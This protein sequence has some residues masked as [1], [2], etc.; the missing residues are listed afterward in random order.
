ML[1]FNI[2]TS[3]GET[4]ESIKRKR[5]IARA[6]LGAGGA[7]R[8]VGEGLNALGDGIVAAV[9]NS[10][11]DSAEKAGMEGAA[12]DWGPIATMFGGG[13][14]AGSTATGGGDPAGDSTS[15]RGA[16]AGIESGGKYD[17]IGPQTKTGDRAYGKYQVMGAN[18]P[19]WTEQALGKRMSV[20]DFLAS[21]EAQD[22]TFDHIFGGYVQ[23]YGPEGAA[24]AWFG[25]PG[26][27][28]KVDRKDILGT[29][30]GSYGKKFMAA[31]GK[32]GA[33]DTMPYNPNGPQRTVEP[34]PN[35]TPLPPGVDPKSLAQPVRTAS[36]DPAA[37]VAKATNPYADTGLSD[38]AYRR[39]LTGETALPV[40]MPGE[41]QQVAGI[42]IG[43]QEPEPGT[44]V[45]PVQ[46]ETVQPI[47]PSNLPDQ[48]AAIPAPDRGL[49][50]DSP[51]VRALMGQSGTDPTNPNG[52]FPAPPPLRVADAAGAVP[53]QAGAPQGSSGTIQALL[54][55]AQNP[56]LSD[57]QR[58]IVKAL[59]G[60]E[61][62]KRDPA[63]QMEQEKARL[64]LDQLRNPKMTPYQEAQ[65]AE[66][67]RDDERQATAAE[68]AAAAQEA[69][70]ANTNLDNVSSLRKEVQN[71]PS[72]KNVAQAAP[73][74]KSM[75][76]TAA[77]DTKASDLNLVYGLAKIM[78]PTSVVREGEV[79]MANDTQGMADY[80]NGIIKGIQG[81]GR[82]TPEGRQA[83]MTEAYSRMKSYQDMY[84]SDIG[85][86]RGIVDRNK[87]NPADVIQ[88]FGTF[89]PWAAPPAVET[90]SAPGAG[91]EVWE[92]GPDGKIRRRP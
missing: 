69:T 51:I 9:L 82:L 89:E 35:A 52:Q 30:V 8:N 19:A 40:P 7:P 70:Q 57:G 36:L 62:K 15:Y 73:I 4:P 2:D 50:P 3:K 53:A 18:I 28:G 48:V 23:K 83:L 16:I 26:S 10:R 75:I 65:I 67:K 33:L 29:D 76:D 84:N 86:Y 45:P 63:Y 80:L 71:L 22:A 42:R 1:S 72:Y 47:D 41:G 64:E 34:I 20:K 46:P 25:G 38:E 81:E 6:L 74:Y 54:T 55:A 88:D 5:D 39:M 11:A 32:G 87:W 68:R 85:M 77:R 31:L 27:V 58:E 24:Q 13:D 37:G 14:G 56:W 17:A 66:Q 59:L 61:L 49:P 78:D 90:P 43:G 92:R 21:P 12:A 79:H 44:V 60:E 91:E